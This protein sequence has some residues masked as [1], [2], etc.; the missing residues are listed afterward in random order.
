MFAAVCIARSTFFHTFAVVR[1]T[2]YALL[3]QKTY[4]RNTFKS[5]FCLST[6]LLPVRDVITSE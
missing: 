2:K 3:A 5:R 1:D 4:V 6:A